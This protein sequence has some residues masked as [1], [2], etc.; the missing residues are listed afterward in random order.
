MQESTSESVHARWETICYHPAKF[1]EI[2]PSS[3]GGDDEQR[4]SIAV[5]GKEKQKET[6]RLQLQATVK[7]SE[8]IYDKD[9]NAI[10]FE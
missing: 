7:D 6:R 3:L 8:F 1:H 5:S 10:F 4:I 2:P 9:Y